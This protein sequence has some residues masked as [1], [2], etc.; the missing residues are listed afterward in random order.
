MSIQIDGYSFPDAA[1]AD[2]YASARDMLALL[3]NAPSDE[4]RDHMLRDCERALALA[5]A[6]L[7]C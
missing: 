6:E 2:R 7:T 3:R 5:T 4:Q 1:A